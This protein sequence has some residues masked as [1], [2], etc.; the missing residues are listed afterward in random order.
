[1]QL[2][3]RSYP[4]VG[5]RISKV[6]FTV[7]KS[8]DGVIMKWEYKAIKMKMPSDFKTDRLDFEYG[9]MATIH[10]QKLN[11]LGEKGWEQYNIFGNYWYFKR[12]I[13]SN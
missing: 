8:K 12:C 10:Q 13:K 3:F 9:V 5:K 11:K 7:R 1:M 6:I 2:Q 4:L